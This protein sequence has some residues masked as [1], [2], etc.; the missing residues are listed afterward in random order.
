MQKAIKRAAASYQTAKSV[1]PPTMPTDPITATIAPI[2]GQS[3]LRWTATDTESSLLELVLALQ[4]YQ[5]DH[6]EYPVKLTDL[7][8]H[9][10][11]AIPDDPFA[12][13]GPPIYRRQGAQYLL[14]SIGPDGIDDGGKPFT[15]KLTTGGRRHVESDSKGDIVAGP[16]FQI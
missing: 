6:H 15:T 2:F 14:Y 4:A 13:S 16:D 8:P 3:K 1:V 5:L 7:V 9:Y 12:K 10:L 11:T